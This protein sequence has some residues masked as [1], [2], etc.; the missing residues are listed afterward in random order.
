MVDFNAS[1]S[2][3]QDHE[4]EAELLRTP[5]PNVPIL[6]RLYFLLR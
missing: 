2:R 5:Y 3:Q 6:A 1:F 4:A